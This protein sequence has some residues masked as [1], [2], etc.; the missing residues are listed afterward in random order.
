MDVLDLNRSALDLN[1]KL[2]ADLEESHLDLPTPCAGWTV[3]ELL[4]HQVEGT[5][6]FAAAVRGTAPEPAAGEDMVDAYRVAA[7]TATEAFG[8]DGVL[9]RE[10]EFPG[11]GIRS[12]KTLVAGHFVDTL[13]HV[14][15]LCRAIGVDSTLDTELAT[16]AFRMARHYPMTPDVRGPGA[17]F[18]LPVDVPEDA[19]ITDR[20][21]GLLGRSPTWSA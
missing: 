10:A 14:W 11:Y 16:A 21:V 20:L 17:A 19:P 1:L 8:A 6:A 9:E 2:M 13:V 5:L 12:G 15:D 3:Y 7:D 4:R 18:A